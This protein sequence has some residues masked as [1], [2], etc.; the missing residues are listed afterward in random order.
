[1][2]SPAALDPRLGRSINDQR[3]MARRI[4]EME[5]RLAR[6]E[7]QV[8][9]PGRRVFW[10]E[11][12]GPFN[13]SSPPT[14]RVTFDI[15]VPGVYL[16]GVQFTGSASTT[17]LTSKELWVD[18]VLLNATGQF[19]NTVNAHHTIALEAGF[20]EFTVGAHTLALRFVNSGATSDGN[21]RASFYAWRTS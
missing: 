6:L 21:D 14:S 7:N 15:V 8:G 2:T 17:G 16:C 4:S 13:A 1:M 11:L 20:A 9:P 12:N 10:T 3:G 19:I 5:R 18:D